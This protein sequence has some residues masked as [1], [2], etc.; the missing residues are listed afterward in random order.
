MTVWMLM[1]SSFWMSRVQ[2]REPVVIGP[3]AGEMAVAQ[4]DP[5]REF[6]HSVIGTR[7]V[8]D[9][10]LGAMHTAHR[11]P[12]SAWRQRH[13]CHR[14]NAGAEQGRARS[15]VASRAWTYASE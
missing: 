3:E 13:S 6:G 5:A 1:R 11:R 10:L 15:A 14:E 8:D 9:Q 2:M 12:S 7:N 4:R